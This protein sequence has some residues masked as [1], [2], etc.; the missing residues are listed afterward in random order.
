[1]IANECSTP[2]D[3]KPALNLVDAGCGGA[4]TALIGDRSSLMSLSLCGM[5]GRGEGLWRSHGDAAGVKLG[6]SPVDRWTVNVGTVPVSPLSVS[7]ADGGQAHRRLTAPG[8]DGAFV[9]VGARENRVH[10]EGGQQVRNKEW[11]PGGR[12]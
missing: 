3:S 7:Q 5:R 12:W 10:G 1:V 8:R 4:G 2:L 9:V 11:D 6:P